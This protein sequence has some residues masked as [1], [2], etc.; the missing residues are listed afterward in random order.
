MSKKSLVIYIVLLFV[1][2]AGVSFSSFSYPPLSDDW[3]VFYSFHHLDQFSG[4]VEWLHI[5]NFDVVEKMGYRPLSHLFYYVLHLVFG[6]NFM[7]FQLFN[8]LFYILSV[9]VLYRFSLYFSKDRFMAAAFVGLF[10]FLFTHFDIVLWSSHIYII[11]GFTMLLLGFMHYMRFLKT[12]RKT[13]LFSVMLLF[14]MGMLCYE[15]FFFWP[16]GIIILSCI[17]E[18]RGERA[19]G[20]H[21]IIKTNAVVLAITYAIYFLFYLFVRS[22]GTYESPAHELGD[23]LK[24][25]SVISSGL[26]VLFSAVYNNIIV[27]IIPFLAFPF[28][29]TENIYMAGPVINYIDRMHEGVIFAGGALV[30][31]LLIFLSVYLHKK[32]R[33]EELKIIWF[34]LFLMLSEAWVI[35]FCRSAT[36]GFVYNL[37]EFRYQY[38]PNAFVILIALLVFTRFLRPSQKSKQIICVSLILLLTLNIYCGQRVMNIY[39]F[40]FANLQKMLSSIRSGIRDGSITKNNRLYIDEDMPDYLPHLCWN[41]YM[42]EQFIDKGNYQWMFSRK[43]MENFSFDPEGARWIIDKEDFKVVKKSPENMAKEGKRIGAG[44]SEQYVTLGDLYKD[45][46]RHEKAENMYKKAIEADAKNDI[47]YDALGAYYKDRSMHKE[48]EDMFKKAIEL[49]PLN[50]EAYADLGHL[51]NEQARYGEAEALFKKAIALNPGY[52]EAHD[53]LNSCYEAQD[54]YEKAGV[55]FKEDI[56]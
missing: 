23:F 9:I 12:G 7:F 31:G 43:E 13:L 26:L 14:L 50:D 24:L 8:F 11:A 33:S 38:V 27:N 3:E 34:F 15:S 30:G 18:L 6:S 55:V 32:K 36:G 46:S 1:I 37:T 51:Y 45:L 21:S 39:N 41:I 42:G 25:S 22:L 2:F 54:I 49:N 16:L 56:E 48:A 19:A 28:K 53:G 47:A 10:A 40:H 35:F 5:L 20:R 4:S 29:V 17:K 44:K 52:S